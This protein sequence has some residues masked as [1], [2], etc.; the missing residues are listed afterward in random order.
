[1]ATPEGF[2]VRLD[3]EDEYT[4]TPEDASNYN[5]SM[6]FNVFDHD[7]KLGGWFRMGNRPNEGYAE[8]SAC[9]YLPDG[10]IAFMFARPKIE[11]NSAMD[12]GGMKF[13]VVEPFKRLKVTYDGNACLMTNPH[14][15]AHPSKAFKEN[16][17]VPLKVSL[18]YIGESPMH[19]GETVNGDGT[20]LKLD[21]EKSFGRAHYE[22]HMSATG[23]F[24]IDGQ[25][26]SVNGLGVRDKSW[27]P[28]FWQA[29]HWYRWLPMNFGPDFGIVIS[30]V[31]GADGQSRTGGMVFENGKYTNLTEASIEAEWDEN[32]YQT[33]LVAKCKTADK[34]FEVTGKVLSLI[35]L[36]NRRK[37]PDG[38]MMVTRITEGMTEYRCGDRVGYGL[39]E[40]LDQIVDEKPVSVA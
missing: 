3:P 14:D 12:A 37:T 29:L 7:Q 6:Y 22:Q 15:M 38:E 25:T 10:R 20:P 9:V 5:E 31:T 27:G 19:G 16:P 33:G 35:P 32:Y 2:K 21:A 39:S 11:D 4:H 1:M 34:E 36:R 26:Y 17:V 40:F 23:T 24:E 18:D 8:M 13:E 28:R 30:V